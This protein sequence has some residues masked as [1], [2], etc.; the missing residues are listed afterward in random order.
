[1]YSTFNKMIIIYIYRWFFSPFQGSLWCTFSP[2]SPR[3][4]W[5]PCM[6]NPSSPCKK[7]ILIRAVALSYIHVFIVDWSSKKKVVIPWLIAFL[8]SLLSALVNLAPHQCQWD[9]A[10]LQYPTVVCI[11]VCVYQCVRESKKETKKREKK[12]H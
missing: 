1:M 8:P 10:N 9:Q 11:C 7:L 3:G 12:T 4:P 2:G 5:I 6:P